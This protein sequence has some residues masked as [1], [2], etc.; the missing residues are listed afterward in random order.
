MTFL[1]ALKRAG[2]PDGSWAWYVRYKVLRHGEFIRAHL[3]KP[4]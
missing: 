1:E 2:T 4:L 3:V